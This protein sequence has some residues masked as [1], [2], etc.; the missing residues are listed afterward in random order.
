MIPYVFLWHPFEKVLGDFVLKI[1]GAAE[2]FDTSP[3]AFVST[4]GWNLP[5][6][7]RIQRRPMRLA[8]LPTTI[9]TYSSAV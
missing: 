1:S 7:S 5:Q 3:P 8:Y 2:A 4:R 9:I 6:T